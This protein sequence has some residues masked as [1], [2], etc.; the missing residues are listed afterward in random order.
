[1]KPTISSP[2]TPAGEPT[3]TAPTSRYTATPGSV[4]RTRPAAQRNRE[5][6]GVRVTAARA[7]PAPSA[8]SEF[9]DPGGIWLG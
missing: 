6:P 5:A 3:T 7:V 4:Q 1:M 8:A 2:G 9:G